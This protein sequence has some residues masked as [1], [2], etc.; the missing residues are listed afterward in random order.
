[1]TV[2]YRRHT[3]SPLT[4][5]YSIFDVFLLLFGVDRGF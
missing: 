3:P 1:V 5:H 4:I 2:G